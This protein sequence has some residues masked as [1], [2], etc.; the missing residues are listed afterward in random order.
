[1]SPVEI[2]RRWFATLRTQLKRREV[3]RRQAQRNEFMRLAGC[4][5]GELATHVDYQR[6]SYWADPETLIETWTCRQ[7]RGVRAWV[8]PFG[9][10]V[11]LD[12]RE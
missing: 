3:A 2:V 10:S 7:H 8:G 5:C 1:M 4:P 12:E 6:A 9:S 11:P